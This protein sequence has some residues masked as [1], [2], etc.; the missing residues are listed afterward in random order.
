[1]K[2]PTSKKESKVSFEDTLEA[3]NRRMAKLG[4]LPIFSSSVNRVQVV[5]SARDTTT[6]ELAVEVMKDA[7]LTT[8]LLRLANSPF[9]NRGMGKITSVSRAVVMLGFET[10]KNMCL[11]L[12]LIESFQ[13]AHPGVDLDRV[14]V[15][16]YLTAGF[17]REI[18]AKGG[19]ADIEESYICGLLHG[20][21]EII[22]A[23]TLPEQYEAMIK[24]REQG[25]MNWSDIQMATLGGS[26]AE[27][28]QNLSRSWDFP[29][30]VV[31]TMQ[32]YRHKGGAVRNK[33]DLNHA[34]ASLSHDVLQK[35]Y[36]EKGIDGVDFSHLMTSLGEVGG[37]DRSDVEKSLMNSFRQSC[38][39][40][41]D[42]GLDKKLLAPVFSETEDAL[43]NKTLRQ[44]SYYATTRNASQKEAPSFDDIEEQ[45]VAEKTAAVVED[46]LTEKTAKAASDSLLVEKS[47]KAG[48][49][50]SAEKLPNVIEDRLTE[51]SIKPSGDTVM[52]TSMPDS[53]TGKTVTTEQ[54]VAREVKAYQGAGDPARQLQTLQEITALISENAGVHRV[55]SKVAEGIQEGV[56]LDR[57][58][59]C[60]LSADQSQL[61]ARLVLGN[62]AEMLKE[63]FVLSVRDRQNLF[64]KVMLEGDDLLINDIDG[65][66]WGNGIPR[67]Y[68]DR[69]GTNGFM[70]AALRVG[71]RPV[72]LFYADNGISGSRISKEAHRSFVQ[73]VSQ[74]RF[75]LQYSEMARGSKK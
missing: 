24:L 70:I 13:H 12:K 34:L 44:C 15:N 64:V 37:I 4:D 33:N 65:E 6:M 53:S 52:I 35:M 54:Q 11:T 19:V 16:S 42:F 72:G 69:V 22:V 27:V 39:L 20:L 47:I 60:L 8:K 7:S 50:A 32:P 51:K 29:Q 57:V 26:L 43:L 75:A 46:R 62:K 55:F 68:Y 38:E 48:G 67:D 41:K 73:F 30:T 1:M 40:A 59:L 21:G 25:E 10:L 17:V 18:A 58:A 74:A 61:I 36:V 3:I 45:Q 66:T 63:Y 14:L 9:Y 28:G 56:G 31:N 49:D 71:K 23:Y 2:A 5:S